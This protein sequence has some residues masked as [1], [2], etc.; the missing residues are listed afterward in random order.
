MKTIVIRAVSYIALGLALS[1]CET[2]VVDDAGFQLWCGETL[3]VWTLE[4]GEMDKVSTW[5]DHD[6]GVELVGAPVLLSQDAR[7]SAQCVRLE[8]VSD[9]DA[10]AVVTVE[11][12]TD[13]DAE[14][15]RGPGASHGRLREPER[16]GRSRPS[17]EARHRLLRAQVG[18]GP[19]RSRQAPDI[20]GVRALSRPPAELPGSISRKRSLSLGRSAPPSM[21]RRKVALVHSPHAIIETLIGGHGF[22]F[23]A[24]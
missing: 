11:I 10:S 23:R 12:D 5:H 15:N 19:R 21:R 3:C 18:G 4:E 20:Q 2:D 6:Y 13:G 24:A 22:P 9:V 7:A 16:R 8:T 17:S 1:A 14:S